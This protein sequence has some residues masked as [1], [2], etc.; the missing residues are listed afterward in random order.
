VIRWVIRL[1]IRRG[2]PQPPCAIGILDNCFP[3]SFTP[4]IRSR[5]PAVFGR[6][7]FHHG[8]FPSAAT[9][10]NGNAVAEQSWN[11]CLRPEG[12]SQ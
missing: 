4:A 7:P 8:S 9:V 5:I 1:V 3:R 12:A 11:V 6:R 10:R 2:F